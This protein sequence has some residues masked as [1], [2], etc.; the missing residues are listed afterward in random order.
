MHSAILDIL[1]R[2]DKHLADIRLGTAGHKTYGGAI[3]RNIPP[4]QQ[5]QSFAGDRILK[6][7]FTPFGFVVFWQ[8]DQ[9]GRITS[10]FRQLDANLVALGLE[11]LMR[12]LVL[13]SK[14]N[15]YGLR[16]FRY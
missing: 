7:F 16:G 14:M 12:Y 4:A 6:D 13:I 11:K 9:T 15:M 2:A 1:T 8:E 3:D 5:G 10:R